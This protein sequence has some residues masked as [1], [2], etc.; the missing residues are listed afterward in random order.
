MRGFYFLFRFPLHFPSKLGLNDEAFQFWNA[1]KVGQK[2]SFLGIQRILLHKFLK[3][4]LNPFKMRGSFFL[5]TFGTLFVLGRQTAEHFLKKMVSGTTPILF[6]MLNSD[7]GGFGVSQSIGYVS[8]IWWRR[9]LVLVCSPF[10]M[11]LYGPKCN[12]GS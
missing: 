5:L 2:N 9:L 4:S 6:P 3:R 12:L 1:I 7:K 8:Y 10:M 11:M